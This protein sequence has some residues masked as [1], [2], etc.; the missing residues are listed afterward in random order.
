M[1]THETGRLERIV[2]LIDADAKTDLRDLTKALDASGVEDGKI[3]ERVQVL[4]ATL[5][6]IH[7]TASDG[8][9]G[10]PGRMVAGE[11]PAAGE[12]EGLR[13]LGAGG[14]VVWRG[15]TYFHDALLP[16]DRGEP[17]WVRKSSRGLLVFDPSERENPLCTAA[18]FEPIVFVGTE[19]EPE[20]SSQ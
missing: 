7:E 12:T 17:V 11:E 4:K 16:Y 18:P 14:S 2:M 6:F 5:D 8:L 15:V 9:R 10:S 20:A 13:R 19:R 3:L 1:K